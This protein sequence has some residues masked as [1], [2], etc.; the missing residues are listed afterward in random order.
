MT[1]SHLVEISMTVAQ[2]DIDIYAELTN[3]FN[4]LH[5]DPTFAAS[6]PM[7]GTIAH[8][9]LSI[10]LI[11]QSLARTFGAG[12][13]GHIDLDIRFLKPLYANHTI[14]AGGRRLSDET[15]RFEVWVNDADGAALIAGHVRL[16]E[17]SDIDPD[18]LD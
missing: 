3:D 6:T 17:L 4:P 14:T 1:A 11:W 9:T 7:R 12:A 8:G 15:R 13:L 18:A 10:N 5:V 2:A 16:S